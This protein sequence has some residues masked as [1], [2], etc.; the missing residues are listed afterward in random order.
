MAGAQPSRIASAQIAASIAPDAPSGW[1][2]SAFV[3]LTG[4]VAARLAERGRDRPRLGDVADRRRRGVRV[5]VVDLVGLDA[6]VG[7]GDRRGPCRLPAVGP[8][9]DHVVRVRRRAVAQELGVRDRAAS[10]GDL[11]RLEHQQRGALAHD[12]PVATG[13][14]RPGGRRRVVVV[15]GRQ[16]PDDVEGAE[17]ERAQRDL[18][19][20]RR[21]RHRPGPR[22]GRPSASPSATAPDAHEFAVDRIGPRTSSAMPRFAGAA[23]PN[24]ASARFGATWPDAAL[25]VAL[26]LLLGVGDAAE[27]RA[28]VDPDPLRVGGRRRRPAPGPRRRA[29]AARRR[30]RTG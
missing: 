7:E 30:A 27:R 13:V 16:R 1:P 12:E 19:R 3:P 26:V 2:Y 6:G 21:S 20:R 25:E 23:P 10:L 24:T 5:D 11:G 28:E 18:A 15:A 14:E 4:T 22:A 8:R 29:P 9:L 17:R